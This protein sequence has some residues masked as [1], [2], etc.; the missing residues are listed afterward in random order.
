M[1]KIT[2][3]D[4]R[5]IA[6]AFYAAFAKG[7]ADK[8]ITY[9]DDHIE[10]ED[11]VFGKLKGNQA[12]MMWKMLLDRSKGNLEIIFNVIETTDNTAIVKW[13][14]RY[15]FS[16]TGRK[17]HNKITAHLTVEEGKIIKHIDKFNLW[18]WSQQA[19]GFKGFLIGWTPFFKA[20]LQH[21]TRDLLNKYIHSNIEKH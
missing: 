18:K 1:R 17:I 10:F 13:E 11:P 6:T 9:Y 21:Q 5:K 14:A 20:K 2:L 19:F 3:M 8:M 15:A 7:D 4:S 16:K 12:K